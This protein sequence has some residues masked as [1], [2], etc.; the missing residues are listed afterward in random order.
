MALILARAF[1]ARAFAAPVFALL[2]ARQPAPETAD[3]LVAKGKALL[4]ASKPDEAATYLD[5]ALK[6]L[7]HRQA[8]AYPFY[9]RAKVYSHDNQVQQAAAALEESVAIDPALAEAWSDLGMARKL[10]LNDQGALAAFQ[11]AVGL[12]PDDAVAQYRLGAE[13]LRQDKPAAAV[14]PLQQAYRLNAEDQ[15]TLNSL[16]IALRQSGK[17]DEADKVK[18]QLAEVL[19]KRDQFSQDAL[20]AV[21]IN[22]EGAALEKAGDLR[23]ALEKYRQ[24][25][26]L[27][28]QHVGIRV[29]YA[30][31][32]L[33][34]GQWSEGLTEL[35]EALNRDPG[36][37]RIKA[38]LD[39]ALAQAPRNLLPDW[40]V[41]R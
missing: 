13:Y 36:N 41:K 24:A 28:P 16:Q 31:A 15:S 26:H 11:H 5:R 34:L 32:L 33:R 17:R 40:A 19:R 23:A 38:A 4:E 35:H 25:L 8:A 3:D 22:N 6:L 1:A 21:G 9:L 7:G 10:L 27:Y 29:N 39:D 2:L 20:K 37:A 14:G 18:A 12:D 30:V